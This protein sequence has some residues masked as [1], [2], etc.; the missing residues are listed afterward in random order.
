MG[1]SDIDIEIRNKIRNT[2]T[3]RYLDNDIKS[4]VT[5][6]DSALDQRAKDWEQIQRLEIQVKQQH[7]DMCGM[8]AMLSEICHNIDKPG[9]VERLYIERYET[10]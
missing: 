6:L 1:I 2:P 4:V 5:A 8:L 9:T 10:P 7:N 3:L